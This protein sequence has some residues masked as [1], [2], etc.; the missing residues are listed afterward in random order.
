MNL[1]EFE[2][3]FK[4]IG[5]KPKHKQKALAGWMG[6]E[7]EIKRIDAI[8]ASAVTGFRETELALQKEIAELNKSDFERAKQAMY[9]RQG[10]KV[11]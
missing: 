11:P 4:S 3:W 6:R 1:G 5:I 8:Y 9:A 10:I 7:V 2:R